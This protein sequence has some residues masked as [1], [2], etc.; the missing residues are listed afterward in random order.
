MPNAFRAADGT[1]WKAGLH[2][3][4]TLPDGSIATEKWAGSATEEKLGWWLRPGTGNV[5]AHTMPV[6]AIGTDDG[7]N[8]SGPMLP[9]GPARFSSSPRRSPARTTASRRW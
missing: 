5:L 6:A 7:A 3:P 4:L 2:I 1:L 9:R 8:R